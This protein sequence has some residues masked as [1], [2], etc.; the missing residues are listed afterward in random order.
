MI[1]TALISV[2][3]KDRKAAHQG[4]R[5]QA[6][7]KSTESDEKQDGKRSGDHRVVR[8]SQR[9]RGRDRHAPSYSVGSGNLL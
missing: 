4:T 8:P 5:R 2:A 7:K 3:R 6:R 9:A 1:V